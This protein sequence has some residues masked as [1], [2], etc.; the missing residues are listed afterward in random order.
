[1]SKGARTGLIGLGIVLVVIGAVLKYAV[2]ITTMGFDVNAVGVILLVVGICTLIKG[3]AIFALGTNRRQRPY[4]AY[5]LKERRS[6]PR[7]PGSRPARTLSTASVRHFCHVRGKDDV[8][9]CDRL[10]RD[11]ARPGWLASEPPPRLCSGSPPLG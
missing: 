1:M 8:M 6:R 11:P 7:A 5:L 3:G 4:R 9:T 2:T 10:D